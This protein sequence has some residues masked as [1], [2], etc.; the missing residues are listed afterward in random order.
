M[1]DP[2]KA[3]FLSYAS[4]DA[5]AA[6]RI[7][8]ALRAAG[9]E[10]W[11]DQSELRGGDAW[12]AKIRKQIKECALFVP[13]ISANTQARR[14]GYFR[15]EWKLAEDRSHLMAR[16]T[17][18]IVP[19]CIDDT[20]DWDALA[21]DSFM[22][23]QWT[24][25]PG[26][27]TPPKFCERIKALSAGPP[28]E[29]SQVRRAAAPSG[30]RLAGFPSRRQFGLIVFAVAILVAA[31][32]LIKHWT[33]TP[34]GGTAKVAESSASF[35]EARKL[36]EKARAVFEAGDLVN[37]E[38]YVLTE[39]LLKKA[40]ELDV[41]EAEAWALHA[42]VSW[43]MDTFGLDTSGE[44][45]EAM[46][47]QAERAVKL[48]PMSISARLAYATMLLNVGGNMDE[49]E[50]ILKSLVAERPDDWRVLH[51]FGLLHRRKGRTDEA[52]EV[53]QR[54]RRLSEDHQTV[55]GD[56]LWM[57][58]IAG[59]YTEAESVVAELLPRRSNGRVL[60]FDVR[61]KLN[62]RGDSAAAAAALGR[63]P[64][65]MFNEDR[66]VQCAA[67]VWMWNREPAKALAALARFPRDYIRH[68]RFTGP[69]AALTAWLHEQAGNRQAAQ[70]DWKLAIQAAD[71]ELSIAPTSSEALHWKAWALARLGDRA[72][73]ELIVR[74]LIERNVR[75]FRWNECT[76]GLVALGLVVEKSDW[77]LSELKN[78][79]AENDG[80]VSS[81][82][83]GAPGL[84]ATR[85]VLDLNPAFDAVRADPQFKAIRATAPAPAGYDAPASAAA[86]DPKS[87]V[88]LP[89]ANL[90]GDK[91]QEYFSDGLTEEIR[92]ALAREHDL[93]VVPRTSAFSFKEK[94]LP[95]PEI[96]RALNV[97]Q[98][99]EGTVRRAGGVVRIT[100]TLTRMSDGFVDPLP[101]LTRELKEGA[102]MFAIQEAV[103]RAV[104]EKLTHRTSTA[105]VA[106]LT[107]NPAAYDSYLRG[108][109]MAAHTSEL[110]AKARDAFQRAVELDPLFAVAWANLAIAE[111]QIFMRT[112][113]PATLERANSAIEHSLRL[114]P[115]L[116]EAYL[117]RAYVGRALFAPMAEIDSDLDRA[118][119]GMPNNSEIL[120]LR[121]FM[122]GSRGDRPAGVSL[123][124]RAAQLDPRNGRIQNVLANMLW[125]A[126]LYAEAEVAN[127]EAFRLLPESVI[128]LINRAGLY[129]AWKG[130]VALVRKTLDEAT[131]AQRDATY[132]EAR[133][134]LEMNGQN[135]SEVEQALAKWP[136][137][138]EVQRR[139][140]LLFQAE[141]AEAKGDHTKSR[142]FYAELLPLLEKEPSLGGTR[143]KASADDALAKLA[144]AYAALGKKEEAFAAVQKALA[145]IPAEYRAETARSDGPLV[146]LAQIHARFGEVEKALAIVREQVAGGFW[147]RNFLVLNPGWSR[148][149]ND[150]RFMALAKEAPL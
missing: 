102:D 67:Q 79:Y 34:R 80:Q 113:E 70:T 29:E 53:L 1:S 150:P 81:G 41:T 88:V 46:R 15:L 77:A 146:A 104:V 105:P 133:A 39:A 19:V 87:V 14:E 72:A 114:Q 125:G 61:L 71:R 32:W 10:V 47:L 93:R 73:A 18:Y 100:A 123:L 131:Q 120:A 42:A 109:E 106:V 137:E 60:E 30:A 49:P 145:T 144:L 3:V 24:R 38:T 91:E 148:L 98:V 25:L 8:E 149:R 110:W 45:K 23:V 21:P 119:R 143:R 59:R 5:D 65:W 139:R 27:E 31:G 36:V 121:S 116:A 44:R 20:K 140:L 43:W 6:R 129:L 103:A 7:C 62:W 90:S 68:A 101:A 69:R 85:A 2:S 56:L 83:W 138:S 28:V 108:R 22:A 75:T 84:W 58:V 12:D 89:F 118:E 128:P 132:W 66:G 94:N 124:Q 95:L 86:P 26:G 48:A 117:A 57:L 33:G 126:G 111:A 74:E 82:L 99:V 115:G 51:G 9:V 112:W 35:S 76:V 147:R 13:I 37:R 63:W 135:W 136:R 96:A 55:T 78:I 11:F 4:Q 50:R 54:A 134:L 52:I 97:A 142:E 17:P 107:K 122:A 127:R 141:L 130:D 16:G 64:A 92:D 40:E